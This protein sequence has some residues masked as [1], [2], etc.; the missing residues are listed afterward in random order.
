MIEKQKNISNE[1]SQKT[2]HEATRLRI[3]SRTLL[4]T[5]RVIQIN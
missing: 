1:L 3:A 2:E 4:S 5:C